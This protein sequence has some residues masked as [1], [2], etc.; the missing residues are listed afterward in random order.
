MLWIFKIRVLTECCWLSLNVTSKRISSLDH[1][2]YSSEHSHI[3]VIIWS[4]RDISE[5]FEIRKERCMNYQNKK[6][7][8]HT[9][10]SFMKLCAMICQ[11][12][13][14]LTLGM[15]SVVAWILNVSLEPMCWRLDPQC[16]SI[17]WWCLFG[18]WLGH[19]DFMKWL[20]YL[21]IHSLEGLERRSM[22]Q[23]ELPALTT[24]SYKHLISLKL[25]LESEITE[26]SD[27]GPKSL[28]PWTRINHSSL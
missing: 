18:R 19:K 15:I 9:R 24:V 10:N 8:T 23:R 17:Q 20:T 4:K 26:P 25:L 16:C 14:T 21:W 2:Q 27:H 12:G 6:T 13:V 28:K 7:H 11:E 22:S 1:K 3:Y 5:N